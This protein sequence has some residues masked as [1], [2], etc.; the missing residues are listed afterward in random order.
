MDPE[1]E[2]LDINCSADEI[3]KYIG[4]SNIWIDTRGTS[5]KKASKDAFLTAFGKKAFT[6]LRILV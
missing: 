2:S 6:L 3:S 4:R 5:D 1:L